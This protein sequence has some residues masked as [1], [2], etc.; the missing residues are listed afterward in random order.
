MKYPIFPAPDPAIVARVQQASAATGRSIVNHIPNALFFCSD[1]WPTS[2]EA[3]FPA[4]QLSLFNAGHYL[5]FASPGRD[6]HTPP[7]TAAPQ[8]GLVL[9][10]TTDWRD[11]VELIRPQGTD[12]CGEVL[13]D[14]EDVVEW[15]SGVEADLGLF[16]LEELAP[17]RLRGRFLECLPGRRREDLALRITQL[18]PWLGPLFEGK[19]DARF[20]HYDDP[21]RHF[22]L[23]LA[24]GLAAGDPSGR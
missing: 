14:V 16:L 24:P 6:H 17:Q 8:V 2:L 13:I 1:L 3:E 5:I 4:L 10:H 12:P 19:R 21:L 11:L 23:A 18:C 15:L 20:V 7:P 22:D 9:V